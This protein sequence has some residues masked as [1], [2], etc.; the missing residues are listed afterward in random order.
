MTIAIVKDQP[1]VPNVKSGSAPNRL[2]G[3]KFT[4]KLAFDDS[5]PT[6]GESLTAAMLGLSSIDF[7]DI[8]PSGGQVFQYDY[9]NSKVL[10]YRSDSDGVADGPLVERANAADLSALT[11]VHFEVVGKVAA[12]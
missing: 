3:V 6:G 10:V 9:T 11:A 12:Y 2:E 8:P 5:Y 7:V 4:G 1:A